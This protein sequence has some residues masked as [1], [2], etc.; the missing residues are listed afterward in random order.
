VPL[1][2]LPS[3]IGILAQ[4]S[5]EANARLMRSPAQP[6]AIDEWLTIAQACERLHCSKSFLYHAERHGLNARKLGRKLLFSQREIET[7]LNQQNRNYL[8]K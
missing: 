5:A 3:L 1:A 2:D 8:A 6:K 4:A 7:Y